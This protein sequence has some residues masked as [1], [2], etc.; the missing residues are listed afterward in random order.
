MGKEKSKSKQRTAFTIVIMAILAIIIVLFYFYW[1]SRTNPLGDTSEEKLSDVEKL[2]Q[3]DLEL[4]YP[5]TPREVMKLFGNMMKTLYNE[6]EDDDVE[7]LALKIRELY[8]SELLVNNPEN[9]YLN[10]LYTDIA[11]WKKNDRR[12]TNYLLVNEDKEEQS[13]IEGVKYSVNYIA[14]TIQEDIKFTETWKVLLRQ[15][16]NK[17]WKIVGWEV[18]PQ[19]D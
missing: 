6:L 16:E 5:E 10:N 13:E 17:K 15:D 14:F 8:D 4:N 19:E 12:I 7:A 18:L 9:T 2:L 11:D 3:K 1:T